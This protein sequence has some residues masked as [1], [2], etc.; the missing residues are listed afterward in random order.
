[1]KKIF[2]V[3][4]VALA[5]AASSAYGQSSY[6]QIA[7][8][9]SKCSFVGEI[10]EESYT[11]DKILGKTVYQ[12]IKERDAGKISEEHMLY[13][14]GIFMMAKPIAYRTPKDAYMAGWAKCMDEK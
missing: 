14:T 8:K 10:W 1:M 13:L 9:Q 2:A 4:V 3:G 7:E 12:Y 11:K 5:L 6:S